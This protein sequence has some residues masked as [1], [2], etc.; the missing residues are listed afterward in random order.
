MFKPTRSPVA[1]SLGR[2][3]IV[4]ALCIQDHF[5][6][7]EAATMRSIVSDGIR[8]VQPLRQSFLA[9]VVPRRKRVVPFLP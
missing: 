2:Y 7:G 9:R 4:P 3:Q 5:L 1:A 8:E 6:R